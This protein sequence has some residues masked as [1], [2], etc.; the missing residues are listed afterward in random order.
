[1]V[2]INGK[3]KT[4]ISLDSGKSKEELE[5]LIRENAKVKKWLSGKK[6]IKTIIIENKLV[7][8]VIPSEVM[9]NSDYLPK[10]KKKL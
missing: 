5:K 1:V 10:Q 8:F 4:V 6:I 3:T 7:N 9:N 2:Q